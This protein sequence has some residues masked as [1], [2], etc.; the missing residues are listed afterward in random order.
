MRYAPINPSPSC[1]RYDGER[2]RERERVGSGRF[3]FCA[4]HSSRHEAQPMTG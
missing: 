4:I 1:A 2:M 3:V